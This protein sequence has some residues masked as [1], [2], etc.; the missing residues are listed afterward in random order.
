MAELTLDEYR[1]ML[2]TQLW[3]KE[4]IFEF[5]EA[6]LGGVSDTSNSLNDNLKSD[7][8]SLNELLA[9]TEQLDNKTNNVRRAKVS[10]LDESKIDESMKNDLSKIKEN[11][12]NLLKRDHTKQEEENEK[13][14]V[15]DFKMLINDSSHKR[16]AKED[17]L[18]AKLK[19]YKSTGHIK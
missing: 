9:M 5:I 7:N 19:H 11:F 18:T 16:D 10:K 15:S 3:L 8:S 17:A 12:N 6:L 14:D 2:G 13:I 4:S 1:L